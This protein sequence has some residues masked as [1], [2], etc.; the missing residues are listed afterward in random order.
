M[1]NSWI[2][3]KEM[4][5][6]PFLWPFL[7]AVPFMDFSLKLWAIQETS[8]LPENWDLYKQFKSSDFAWLAV[9]GSHG[10]HGPQR[11]GDKIP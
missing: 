8:P 5:D 2:V 9:P 10:H 7:L 3:R 11:K 6:T 1:I 4:L